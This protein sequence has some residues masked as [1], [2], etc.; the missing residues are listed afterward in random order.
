MK[1][2]DEKK[3]ENDVLAKENSN[4]E[5]ELIKD[6]ELQPGT[7]RARVVMQTCAHVSGA[8]FYY[9][10]KKHCS[11]VDIPVKS[12]DEQTRKVYQLILYSFFKV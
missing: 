8:A 5:I 7:R 10:P 3:V 9:D 4:I 11:N 6:Y 12:Q 1:F 2:N